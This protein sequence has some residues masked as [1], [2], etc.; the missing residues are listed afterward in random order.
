MDDKS[1]N[2]VTEFVI[3][4]SCCMDYSDFFYEVELNHRHENNTHQTQDCRPIADPTRRALSFR[5]HCTVTQ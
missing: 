2:H 1:W 5:Q 3:G 4:R